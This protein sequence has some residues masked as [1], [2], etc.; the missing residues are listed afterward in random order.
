MQKKLKPFTFF[1]HKVKLFSH[2]WLFEIPWT[3]A[4][5]APPSMEFSRQDYWCGFPF[6][7]AGDLPNPGIE[8]RSPALQADALPSEP[9]RKSFLFLFLFFHKTG[10]KKNSHFTVSLFSSKWLRCT[11]KM[12]RKWSPSPSFLF[13]RPHGWS[14]HIGS[15][16]MAR[17][18]FSPLSRMLVL[19]LILIWYEQM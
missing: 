1:F 11:P 7:S 8:P 9:P 3:V 18:Q 14:F 19:I 2:V 13:P 10:F 12:V 4:Y 6:P 17:I 5:Q 15:E 16:M